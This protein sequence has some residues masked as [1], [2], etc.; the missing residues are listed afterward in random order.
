MCVDS[1]LGLALHAGDFN[2][3]EPL[4]GVTLHCSVMRNGHLLPYLHSTPPNQWSSWQT[5]TLSIK[6]IVLF[7][8][9][10]FLSDNKTTNTLIKAFFWFCPGTSKAARGNSSLFRR[11]WCLF[12]AWRLNVWLTYAAS[13]RGLACIKDF[14]SLSFSSA[15]PVVIEHIE[16]WS[17]ITI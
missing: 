2:N 16:K 11:H 15:L 7:I 13:G 6:R 4:R 3:W 5:T 14:V 17:L 10:S 9:L 12:H 1:L 8:Y